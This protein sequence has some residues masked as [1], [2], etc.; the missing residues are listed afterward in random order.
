MFDSIFRGI[1]LVTSGF[2]HLFR[3]AGPQSEG[4]R[5][6]ADLMLG[7]GSMGYPGAWTA[8]RIELARH[9]KAWNYIAIRAIAEE[10]ACHPPSIA[11]VR[12]REQAKAKKL[13]VLKSRD[14]RKAISSIQSHEELE[15][16]DSSHPLA[17]L[18]ANPNE[19]DVAWD[20]WFETILYLE[21]Q[22]NSYWWVV[23]NGLGVPCELWVLPAHW[24]WPISGK[25]KIV[26]HYEVR[27]FGVPGA[28]RQIKFR[29]DEIIHFRYKNPLSKIDGFAPPTAGA[30][31]ID[32]AES[33]DAERYY[34]F[35]NG[36]WPGMVLELDSEFGEPDP[37][38]IKA[39]YQQ[40]SERLRG[41]NKRQAPI[42][43]PPGVTPHTV[44]RTNA[45]MDYYNSA[46]Q[47]K[48][49][50]LAIHRVGKSIAGIAEDVNYASMIATTANFCSRT[51]RPK[52]SMIGQVVTEKLAKRFDPSLMVYWEDITPDDP[53]QKTQDMYIDFACDAITPNEIRAERGREPLDG[54][55]QTK[56][57]SQ[58]STMNPE[59]GGGEGGPGISERTWRAVM[60][61]LNAASPNLPENPL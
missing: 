33:M 14:R 41:E 39:L 47:M 36:V 6:M 23:N 19:P 40:F 35:K 7:G 5:R 21:Q 59:Q 8:D 57:Q 27:P 13:N 22:G 42:I 51:I 20:F 4:S 37:A 46:D 29:A 24:V 53:A 9:Y 32:S 58:A 16:V 1:K 54:G 28:G 11:I 18:L 55:D 15:P 31:W 34:G 38:D 61:Q 10:I 45:E 52:L 48:D 12:T 25:E 2:S 49:W 60:D 17:R 56:S 44:T 26:D 30:E 50:V 43:L 3:G